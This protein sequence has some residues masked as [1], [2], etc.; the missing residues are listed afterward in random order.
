ML[1]NYD[2]AIGVKTGFTMEA[3]RC[4]V[5]SAERGGMKLVSV[6]LNSPQM[7]ERSAQ[8]L[9]TAFENYHMTTLCNR[10]IA[11]DKCRCLYDFIYPLTAAEEEKIVILTDLVSPLPTIA[12]EFAGQM[13]IMLENNLLFSQ[14]LYIME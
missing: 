8:L 6:V 12:G 3:G 11:I 9:D 10:E 1:A 13:K 4:L 2:G 14:N 5:T 7:Y